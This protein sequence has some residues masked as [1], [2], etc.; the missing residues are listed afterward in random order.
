MAASI[1]VT[2]V[3]KLNGLSPDEWQ[4]VRNHLYVGR[5]MPIRSG[6]YA[7]QVWRPQGWGNPFKVEVTDDHPTKATARNFCIEQYESW[8]AGRIQ[9][10]GQTLIPPLLMLAGKVLGCW[11]C[12]W[13]GQ[14]PPRPLCHAAVLADWVNRMQAGERPW[15]AFV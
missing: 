7:G 2:T 3:Q 1:Q 6:R 14:T 4:A 15:E 9:T 12:T 10:E 11:C 8:L 5:Y 13:D